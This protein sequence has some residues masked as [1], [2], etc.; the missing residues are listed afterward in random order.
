MKRYSAII[1]LALLAMLISAQTVQAAG[2][3]SPFSGTWIGY[4]VSPA[5]GGDGSTE[6]LVVKGGTSP[7]I[8]YQDEFGQVCWDAGATDFWFHS[9]LKGSVSGS[10]MTGTFMRAWCG[11]LSLST[12]FKGQT[13]S[14]TF[15]GHGTADPSDDTLWDGVVTWSRV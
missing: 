6:H 7:R 4:D 13:M 11:H 10:T 1:T 9:T 5:D 14:W 2:P 15:N 3:S 8:D 12:A